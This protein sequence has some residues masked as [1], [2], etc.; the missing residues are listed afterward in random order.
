MVETSNDYPALPIN[1][2][3]DFT[4]LWQS[5]TA[6]SFDPQL[7]ARLPARFTLPAWYCRWSPTGD[8]LQHHCSGIAQR[9]RLN[10]LHTFSFEQAQCLSFHVH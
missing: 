5:P 10:R 7:T 2:I 4:G 8:C 6:V 9:A 3:N 1:H